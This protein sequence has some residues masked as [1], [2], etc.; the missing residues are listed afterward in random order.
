MEEKDREESPSADIEDKDKE[1]EK[2]ENRCAICLI[3]LN[4]DDGT[5]IAT[6]NGCRH[7]F[8]AEC[9]MQWSSEENTCPLVTASLSIST[10]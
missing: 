4:E 1:S 6:L 8:H 3:D 5:R 9:I 7:E 10:I 2:H